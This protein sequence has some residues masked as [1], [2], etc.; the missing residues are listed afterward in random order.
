MP[1]FEIQGPDGKKY[2]VDTP[3]GSTKQDAIEYI[4]HT[5]YGIDSK[6]DTTD[7]LTGKPATSQPHYMDT[8][9]PLMRTLAGVGSGTQ[10]LGRGIGNIIGLGHVLPSVFGEEHIKKEAEL[11][12]PISD[13]T[14]GSIGQLVGQ[15]AA[16]LPLSLGLGAASSALRAVPVAGR[17]LGSALARGGVEGGVNAAALADV[18]KQGEAAGLGAAIGTGLTAGLGGLGRIAS[19]IVRKSK[20]AQ[21]LELLASQHGKD[22]FVPVSQAADEGADLTSRLASGFYKEVLPNVPGAGAQLRSQAKKAV[23]V[24]QDMAAA[25]ADPT[26][27]LIKAGMGD[28][29]ITTRRALAGAFQSAY[30][31]TVGAYRFNVPPDFTSQVAARIKTAMPN[32]DNTTLQK[33]TGLIEDRMSRFAS[34]APEIE[35]GN[36]LNAKR[37]VD[38]LTQRLKGPELEALN[39]GKGVFDD[40]VSDEL[41]QGG[42]ASNLA[43]LKKYQDLDEPMKNFQQYSR[44]VEAAKAEGGSVSPHQ[45][46]QAADPEGAMF[47]LGTTANKVLGQPVEKSSAIGK[48]ATLG[49]LGVYGTFAHGLVPAAAG[50]AITILA[51][52]NALATKIAQRIVMGDTVAQK[53]VSKMLEEHP[54]MRHI[55]DSV[56]RGA[57]TTSAGRNFQQ[58]NE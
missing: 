1:A 11:D 27:T 56:I 5:H 31:S 33:V 30:D 23:G 43:D 13:T 54:G 2:R 37:A 7:P 50:P 41:S 25:E 9:S 21:D 48:V 19:G 20:A 46:A 26:G 10:E 53:A 32:V 28:E 24:V 55:V 18:D 22:M 40:I 3:E 15:T 51:G 14:S 42:K 6:P 57:A 58:P 34:G 4:A 44:A 52:G 36:L 39:A 49:S 38:D 12:R 29:G 47:H 35:G 17:V 16:S 45:L 8:N